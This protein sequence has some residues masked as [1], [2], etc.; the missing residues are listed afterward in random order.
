MDVADLPVMNPLIMVQGITKQKHVAHN[1]FTL[2]FNE[3]MANNRHIEMDVKV[4]WAADNTRF[5]P[6]VRKMEA[7]SSMIVTGEFKERN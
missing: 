7:G 6:V 4:Y 5:D 3:Y 1:A 2:T